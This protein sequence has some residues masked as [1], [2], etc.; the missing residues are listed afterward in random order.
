M[1]S[2]STDSYK[3]VDNVEALDDFTVK[4]TFKKVDP[5]WAL[6]FTGVRGMILPEHVFA[7]YNNSSAASAPANLAPVGTG[8]YLATEFRKEDTLLIGEDVVNTVKIFYEPNPLYRDP[9]KLRFKHLTLQGGGDAT[10]AA[11]A[12]LQEGV[13]DWAWNLQVDDKTLTDMETKG[14]GKVVA[15]FGAYTERLLLNFSD[16]NKETPEGERSSVLF[17]NPYFNDKRVIETLAY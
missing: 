5:A 10:V 15:V 9:S 3:A 7:Q 2:T 4:V 12:V 11:K 14:A 17:P 1:K 13:V 16:P 8:P 6:P